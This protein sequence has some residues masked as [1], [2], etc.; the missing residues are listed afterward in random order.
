MLS[1]VSASYTSK[2]D[3]STE[4]AF[5]FTSHVTP[6]SHVPAN[7][8]LVRV[9][10]VGLDGVDAKLAAEKSGVLD[11]RAPSV[12]WVPGRS[13]VGRAVEIGSSLRE[14]QVRKGDWVVGLIDVHKVN[15]FIS[16][17]FG[18]CD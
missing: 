12:G 9:A 16:Q 10:A 1:G 2:V 4:H 8:V 6:P 18:T 3:E 13:I 11:G 5:G 15:I 14:G 17:R 7:S